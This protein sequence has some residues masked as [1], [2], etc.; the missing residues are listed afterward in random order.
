MTK[1][2]QYEEYDEI[3]SD[4][5]AVH[6]LEDNDDS[7]DSG[8]DKQH[9]DD[10]V[11]YGDE[12]DTDDKEGLPS[13][14][15]QREFFKQHLVA[16]IVAII[17]SGISYYRIIQSDND[18]SFMVAKRNLHE[19][20][21]IKT[22]P[23]KRQ[24]PLKPTET[25]HH[26]EYRRMSNVFFCPVDEDSTVTS[27]SR[28]ERLK[29]VL[30]RNDNDVSNIDTNL[31]LFQFNFPKEYTDIV[32][33]YYIADSTMDDSYEN[34]LSSNT[35]MTDHSQFHCLLDATMANQHRS[36]VPT[37]DIAYV[38][39]HI[40]SFYRD[41]VNSKKSSSLSVKT[42]LETEKED[43]LED[44]R[45]VSLTYTG[46]T[47]K[48]INLSTKPM[49]LYWDGKNKPKFRARIEPFEAF[50]T[51]T[52]PGNSFYLAPVYDKEHAMERWIMTADE[53]VVF[54]DAIENDSEVLMRLSREERKLYEMQ[55]LNIKYGQ[56]YLVKTQRSWLSMFPRPMHMHFMWSAEYYGQ[57]HEVISDQ[58][59]FITLPTDRVGQSRIWRHLDY[60]DYDNMVEKRKKASNDGDKFINLKEYR[61]DGPLKLTLKVISVAP[62]VF[63]IDGFLSDSEVS[64]LL[65]LATMYNVTETDLKGRMPLKKNHGST[66]A[67]IR[68]EMSPIVDAIYHRTADMLKIDESLLRHRN[69]HEHT[70]LNTHHSIAEALFLTQFIKDQGYIPRSDA[71]QTSV[72]NRY[73]P[74]R[75]ATV[76]FFLNDI[77]ED[78]GGDTIFPLAVN[79]HHHDGVRVTPKKGKA[80]L[81]YNMLPDGNVDDLSQHS[82][83]FLLDGEKW[84]GSLFLWDP[85]ID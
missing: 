54:Y 39:P 17:A 82:S 9:E 42:V 28:S 63:E 11:D 49:N 2:H 70:E 1:V 32:N 34:V 7:E 36:T 74:N 85:I 79:V 76:V 16:I 30:S 62:R 58:S 18:F 10:E 80:V 47:A 59:H 68:R 14:L 57:E 61:N 24:V 53:A 84:V 64:H 65:D 3:S 8:D 81:F 73:Q 44:I 15:F 35:E 33:D 45:P 67:W 26:H 83:E 72:R 20:I 23:V 22:V 19:R 40:R 60:A 48:F 5:G 56:D 4:L 27:E 51:V 21:P 25:H 46:F 55:K 12:E 37:H 6:T 31:Q 43:F 41:E 77:E 78:W 29:N 38:Q 52:T 69:E 66:N 71:V 75:F 50:S 13:Y